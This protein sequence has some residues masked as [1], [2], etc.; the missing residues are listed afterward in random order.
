MTL[1]ELVRYLTDETG[2]SIVVEEGLERRPVYLEIVDQPLGVVLDAVAGR[3][4]VSL[5]RHGNLFYLGEVRPD[6]RGV[7]VRRVRRLGSEDLQKAVACQLSADGRAVA[8]RDGLCIV[9]DRV[10]VLEKVGSLLDGIEQADSPLWCVQLYVV[11]VAVDD[12]QEFG[13]DVAPAVDVSLAFAAAS[14]GFAVGELSGASLRGGIDAVL[15]AVDEARD[16]EVLAEPLFLL[17]DGEEARFRRGSR[18]PYRQ[19]MVSQEGTVSSRTYAFVDS[20]LT[21]RVNLRERGP[22]LAW[23]SVDVISNEIEG[24][25]DEQVPRLGDESFA[26]KVLLRSGGVYLLGSLERCKTETG[27]ETFL[28]VGAKDSVERRVLQVWGTAYAVNG[29]CRVMED[30]GPVVAPAG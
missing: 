18:L 26:T 28:R 30:C 24:Y 22:G 15:Q 8:Y 12:L 9:C 23:L 21:I 19:D 3:V 7:L 6:A 16:S 27:R 4:G 1:G 2:A 25:V 20:G 13:L 5:D 11:S 14:Q 17:V 29:D 10:S